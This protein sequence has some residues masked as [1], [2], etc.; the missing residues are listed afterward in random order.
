MNKI[1]ITGVAGFI[2]YHLA[3][4]LISNGQEVF[5]IDNLN[6]YYDVQ[7]KLDRL[8]DLGIDTRGTGFLQQ[9]LSTN[10][11]GSLS[12]LQLDL[13]DEERL[14]ELFTNEQFDIVVNLAA[15]AGV[16]Y[17]IKNPKAYIN[18]NIVG[19]TNLLEAC[20]ENPVKHL[21]FASSSSVYGNQQKVPFSETDPVD[22]PVSLYAATKKSNEL[23]A[24]TYHHL[25]DIPITGLRFFTVYGPWGRP[26][27]APFLFTQAILNDQ[28]IKVFNHG[29]L[30]RDFTYIDDIIAGVLSIVRMQVDRDHFEVY[31]I[32]NNKPEKLLTF[33]RLLE[34]HLEKESI[35]EMYPMQEGDVYQ[36]F[37]D[38]QKLNLA[39]GYKPQIPIETG[40]KKFVEWYLNYY[41]MSN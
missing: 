33:I 14:I 7:L 11:S 8:A 5:G 35:K 23:M 31:N 19:F 12:F 15:Q 16:R 36:T 37:A 30:L 4:A 21:I 29:D 24:H 3:K 17:S 6:T 40:L 2:G 18:A 9:E 1:L 10:N 27:M 22:H 34:K 25:Y 20:R 39:T 13:C 32:G 28:P 26:D 38:T 41:N